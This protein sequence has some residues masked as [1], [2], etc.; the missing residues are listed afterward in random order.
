[1]SFFAFRRYRE[2]ISNLFSS[3]YED[4]SSGGVQTYG[5]YP[6]AGVPG[7]FSQPPFSAS[8]QSQSTYQPPT[9]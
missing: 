4:H 5:G 8:Q 3:N 6:S 7:S 2:G 1:M 9:Y